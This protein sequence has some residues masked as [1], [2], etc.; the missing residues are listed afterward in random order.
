MKTE[1]IRYIYCITNLINGKTY[2]GQHTITEGSSI[3]DDDYYGSGKLLWK[4]YKKY[5]KENFER[6][7]II[8]GNFT[9]EQI[10]RFEKCIIRIQRFL[11]K[12]EYNLADGGGGGDTSRFINYNESFYK[13]RLIKSINE[14][15]IKKY[16]SLENY[17]E[18]MRNVAKKG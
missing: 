10:N 6:T 11:G 12:A 16:G 2:Y 5:G 18:H 3:D 15:R 8:S 13:E 9:K 14:S 4:A 7:Y 17:A 1:R